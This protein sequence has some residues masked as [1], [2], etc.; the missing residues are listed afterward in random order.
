VPAA[1]F[2]VWMSNTRGNTYSRGHL[3]YKEWQPEYW[4]TSIDTLAL[5]DL[6]AMIDYTLNKTGAK[7][8]AYVGHSQVRA[9]CAVAM[10]PAAAVYASGAFQGPSHQG[11]VVAVKEYPTRR[12]NACCQQH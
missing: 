3:V 4:Y 10:K 12:A 1:G 11:C 9:G 7:K 6:P 2:D 8:V 5:K